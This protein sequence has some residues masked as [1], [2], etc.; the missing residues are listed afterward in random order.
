MNE[1]RLGVI[2]EILAGNEAGRFVEI[3]DD[4]E[5]TRGYHLPWVTRPLW[6]NGWF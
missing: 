5:N 4:A 1:I 2:G 3:V 6:G